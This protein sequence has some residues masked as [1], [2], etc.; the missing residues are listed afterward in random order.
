ML[1]SINLVGTYQLAV[2]ETTRHFKGASA[3]ISIERP[4]SLYQKRIMQSE[5]VC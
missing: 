3:S 2:I 4:S 5:R 1:I